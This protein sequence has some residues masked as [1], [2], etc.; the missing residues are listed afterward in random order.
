MLHDYMPITIGKMKINLW[1]LSPWHWEKKNILELEWMNINR[2]PLTTNL[3]QF[4]LFTVVLFLLSHFYLDFKDFKS[5]STANEHAFS[6]HDVMS[7]LIWLR[8]GWLEEGLPC[9]ELLLKRP[10]ILSVSCLAAGDPV[11]LDRAF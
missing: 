3:I 7:T 5:C 6:F 1:K 4:I 11:V 10:A 8:I 2:N 9:P